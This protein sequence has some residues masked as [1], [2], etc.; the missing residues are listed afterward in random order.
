[1]TVPVDIA[2]AGA[3]G[4]ALAITLGRAGHPVTLWA[5][6]GAAA[7]ETA[8][9]NAARLPGHSLP[10]TVRVTGALEDLTAEIL[11]I[12][13]PTQKLDDFLAGDTARVRTLVSCA[14][15]IHRATGLGPTALIAQARPEAQVAQLTGPSFAQDL[16][17]GLPTALTLACAD[18]STGA[19]LQA[20]LSTPALRLYRSTDVIGAEL[21]GAL[22]NVIAIAAGAVIGAG[23]GESARA[24]LMARG[25]AEMRRVASAAGAEDATLSGL[26]GLGDLVLTCTSEKS[27][28]MR[29][30]MA[31]ARGERFDA[32]I[33]VEGLATA[34]ELAARPD[35]DTPIAEAVAALASGAATLEAVIETLLTR[36]LKP[37]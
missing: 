10:E 14:K 3:F 24:A 23:L 2:G 16:A 13:I 34:Q 4:T 22:K 30:G 29:F 17:S 6:Q 25:F 11:I 12:A 31:L 19:A 36:P 32:K 8:R 7:I 1:M 20:A 18:D 27:R 15:G 21:G 9:E 28:N 26:S 35:L 37:E 5:R 33:T